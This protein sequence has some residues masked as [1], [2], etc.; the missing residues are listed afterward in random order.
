[1]NAKFVKASERNASFS[2]R[3]GAETKT[4]KIDENDAIKLSS[5]FG[6]HFVVVEAGCGETMQT[7]QCWLGRVFIHD[8]ICTKEKRIEKTD[9]RA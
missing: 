9:L 4:Q 1:M 7:K 3:F 8:F 6:K 2:Y 5:Q